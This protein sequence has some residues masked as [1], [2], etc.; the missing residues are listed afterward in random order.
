VSPVRR[1]RSD[2]AGPDD[3]PGTQLGQAT[4]EL[5]LIMP[6]LI[7]LILAIVQIGVLVHTRV[8]VTH[9]A[10]EAVR[11]AAVGASGSAVAAA[12]AASGSLSPERLAVSLATTGDRVE[13]R[14]H[15]DAPT[16]VFLVV[17]L[18]G[19]VGFDASA[20]MRRED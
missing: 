7:L 2:G 17:P 6:L 14:V 9:A 16:D 18:L 13:V 3:R 12:A 4:V 10:R 20:T 1:A 5:A 11:E 8:L 19:D 15:Y